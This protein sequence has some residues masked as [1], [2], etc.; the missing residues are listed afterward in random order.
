MLAAE[1]SNWDALSEASLG[2]DE[3]VGSRLHHRRG[4]HKV[5]L[6]GDTDTDDAASGAP[7]RSR[8]LL[9]EAA[10]ATLPRGE[11]H[12]VFTRCWDHLRKLIAL[13]KRDRNNS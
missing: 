6:S 12:V 10:D 8:L 9:M 2:E 11:H 5:T 3:E 7:H 1:C 13:I 4:H